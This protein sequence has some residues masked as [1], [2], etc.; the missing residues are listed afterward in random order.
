[1]AGRNSSGD[2]ELRKSVKRGETR[3]S[4]IGWS[5][6]KRG[7]LPEGMNMSKASKAPMKPKVRKS[8]GS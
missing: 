2:G 1:M 5:P 3:N 7:V 4:R 6:G 8:I